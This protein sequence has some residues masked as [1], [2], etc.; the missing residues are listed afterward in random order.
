MCL[1]NKRMMYDVRVDQP[2]VRSAKMLLEQFGGANG[3]LTAALRYFTRGW[4]E[5]DS[6]R[7]SMLLDI[8][9]EELS[10]LEMGAP[11]LVM[12]LKGSASDLVDQVEGAGPRLTDSMGAPWTAAYSDTIGE[13]AAYGRI[14][15]RRRG[16][17]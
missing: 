10:V 2:G 17:R 7:R 6:R 11:A 8:A 1:H 9:A 4:S 13:P 15:P 14:S 5:S 12:L 3:E 16:R